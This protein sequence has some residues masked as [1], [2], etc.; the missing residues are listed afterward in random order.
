VT[1]VEAESVGRI[2]TQGLRYPRS[3]EV[4]DGSRGQS[5]GCCC[6]ARGCFACQA[7]PPEHAV[8]GTVLEHENENVLYRR[9]Q[10]T[11]ECYC[12]RSFRSASANETRAIIGQFDVVPLTPER[13]RPKNRLF[14]GCKRENARVEGTWRRH[15]APARRAGTSR[16]R[17]VVFLGHH[18]VSSLRSA[19]REEYRWNGG[20]TMPEH[21]GRS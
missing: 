6:F 11:S 13:H 1:G 3:A 21:R 2:L 20:S 19:Q 9:H 15:V 17:R 18:H 4:D 8:I 16:H 5:V 12:P 7:G 14:I 10:S